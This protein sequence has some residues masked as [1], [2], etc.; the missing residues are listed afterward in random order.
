[1]KI[2]QGP[3]GP[4]MVDDSFKFATAVVEPEVEQTDDAPEGAPS[5]RTTLHKPDDV[6]HDE[7]QRRRDAV[8][9]LAREFD[10][11]DHGDIREFLVGRTT[12]EL[13]D[14]EVG[15]LQHD[16][17]SQRVS[18]I[19]DVLDEQLRSTTER[20]KRARRTVRV[21]APRGWLQRAF[22]TLDERAAGQVA[23]RLIQR[24][25]DPQNVKEKVIGRVKD[26][27]TRQRLEDAIDKEELHVEFEAA[28]AATTM[29]VF[30]MQSMTPQEAMEFATDMAQTIAQNIKVPEIHIE[31]PVNVG[32]S[33]KTI[34][35][36]PE[37]GLV[38][39]ISDD[40]S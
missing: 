5:T 3:Q 34:K 8:R 25:H 21:Q 4:M 40:G 7:W 6:A 23:A 39:E 33:K 27:E 20:M 13:S 10:S 29:P 32:G 9:T 38:T 18:D 12:R 24:G 35:R 30:E 37:T 28:T 1:M 17:A 11:V 19:T 31:V 16:V 15:Q 14:D 2:V 22:G 26:E 36:D